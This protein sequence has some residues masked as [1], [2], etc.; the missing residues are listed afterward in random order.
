VA[1]STS[2]Y[3]REAPLTGARHLI[4][5][6]LA[7]AIIQC[8]LCTRRLQ[9]KLHRWACRESA[10][11]TRRVPPD[12]ASKNDRFWHRAAS[13]GLRMTKLTLHPLLGPLG[14]RCTG[15][16]DRRADQVVHPCNS[17]RPY[18]VTIETFDFPPE[19]DP[20]FLEIRGHCPKAHIRR[21]IRPEW[22]TF[23]CHDSYRLVVPPAQL[24]REPRRGRACAKNASKS[25]LTVFRDSTRV[26]SDFLC[27]CLTRRP[28]TSATLSSQ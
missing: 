9:S 5:S 1:K 15:S 12:H 23:P 17:R 24:A 8:T 6:S 25:S 27:K 22:S 18:R 14:R 16:L 13:R 20:S 21:G 28:G 26:R 7:D 4:P 19:E 2:D 11:E 3:G 10:L